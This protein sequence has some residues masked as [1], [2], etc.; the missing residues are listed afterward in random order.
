MK[1]NTSIQIEK[2]DKILSNILTISI[3]LH[4]FLTRN[5]YKIKNSIF[6]MIL[7]NKK[8]EFL[9]LCMLQTYI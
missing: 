8:I 5:T 2:K 6:L 3:I 1:K 4:Y 7:V 9:I